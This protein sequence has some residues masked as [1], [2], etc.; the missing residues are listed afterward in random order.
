MKN[1]KIT[2][3]EFVGNFMDKKM[4][5][6]GMAYGMA[7]LNFRDKMEYEAEKKWKAKQNR[8]NK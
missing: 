5:G 7:Y 1:K 6:H 4:K 3:E 2:K 8:L